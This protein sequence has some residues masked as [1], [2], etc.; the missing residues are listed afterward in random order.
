MARKRLGRLP[1]RYRFALNQFPEVRW[2]K[3]PRCRKLT[4]AR[5][6]PL[7][8]HVEGHGLVILGKTCRYCTPCEFIVAHQEELETELAILF[9]RRRP[10]V[11]GNDY[12]VVGTVERATWEK[13]LHEALEWD[14]LFDHAADFKRYYT[15]EDP[16][17]R[18]V[19]TGPDRPS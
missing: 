2:S 7:L 4:H 3:C 13:G 8:V 11:L 16:R 5:K 15:L 6:F 10:E 1:P 14:E 19:Y 18:W 17:P 9:S 12:L